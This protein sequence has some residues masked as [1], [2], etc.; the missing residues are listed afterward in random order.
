MVCRVGV[1][2]LR[3]LRAR[4]QRNHE[5]VRALALSLASENASRLA[6][7]EIADRNIDER[8][9]ALIADFRHCREEAITSELLDLV[10]A[11]EALTNE[12]AEKGAGS[13]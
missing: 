8:Q 5:F 4:G 7:M 3:M 1:Q 2:Q 9:N 6:A 11:F 10:T 13:K 12:P